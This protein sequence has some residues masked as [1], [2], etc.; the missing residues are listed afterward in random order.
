MKSPK[1]WRHWRRPN[2]W[3]RRLKNWQRKK[4]RKRRRRRRPNLRCKRPRRP[5]RRLRRRK[6]KQRQSKKKS[7]VR[8]KRLKSASWRRNAVRKQNARNGWRPNSNVN[9]SENSLKSGVA[10]A[11]AKQRSSTPVRSRLYSTKSLMPRHLPPVQITPTREPMHQEALRLA[12]RK[13]ATT[14]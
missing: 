11:S 12:R 10:N 9:V 2:R 3:A 4:R 14:A 8:R 5:R 13:A 7:V 6:E 1:N